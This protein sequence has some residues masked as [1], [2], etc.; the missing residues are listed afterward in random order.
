ML[1]KTEG[2]NIN[3]SCSVGNRKPLKESVHATKGRTAIEV[4]HSSLTEEQRDLKR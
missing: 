1:Q 3:C 2:V 4:V